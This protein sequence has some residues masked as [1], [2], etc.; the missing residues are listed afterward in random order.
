MAIYSI[1]IENALQD[2]LAATLATAGV[3]LTTSTDISGKLTN[4]SVATPGIFVVD[5]VDSNG[6]AT[7][8]KREYISF[9]GAS[10][11]T[12]SG[13]VRGLGGSSDQEHSAGAII[14]FVMDVTWA[15][16]FYDLI[17]TSV[18]LTGTQTLTNKTLTAPTLTTPTLT[19]PIIG[20]S[21]T[22][23]LGKMGVSGETLQFGDGAGSVQTVT[24]NAQTATLTN[25][26]IIQRVTTYQPDPAATATLDLTT[27]GIQR[28]TLPA[29]N[30]TLAVSNE[31]V[32][33]C[34]IVEITQ[35][36]GGSRTVTWFTTIRWAGGSA[37]TLTTT[38]SKR[39]VFGFRVT[40]TDTYDG[41][42][43]GMN[44]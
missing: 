12:L 4:A 38:A 26:T 14:E 44:I 34:F 22:N 32:G 17:A 43:V 9:T 2:Q 37:P 36:D 20:G 30:V 41:Y 25:K 7:P 1:P 15:Q 16:G 31:V 13:L 21:A 39:D 8:T 6:V 11:T 3:S 5:R 33:Q 23:T 19:A 29:G 10:D 27:G 40:G 24:A 18:T 35:D 28:V 42:V